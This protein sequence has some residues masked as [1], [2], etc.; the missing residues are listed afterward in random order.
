MNY[1]IVIQLHG[2][3]VIVRYEP[4]RPDYEKIRFLEDQVPGTVINVFE[5][6]PL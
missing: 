1:G 6:A 3:S 4:V 2:G 5:L